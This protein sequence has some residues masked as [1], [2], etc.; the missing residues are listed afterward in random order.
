VKGFLQRLDESGYR[1]FYLA[2]GDANFRKPDWQAGT[3][4]LSG[5]L[6]DFVG[7]FLLQEALPAKRA[8]RLLDREFLQ[9]LVQAGI[10]RQEKNTI[11]SDSFYLMYCRS[12]AF[13][14]QMNATPR[15]YFG[16]DSVALAT[17]QTPVPG[18][19][20]LDLC[21]GPGIQSFIAAA[22]AASVTGVEIRKETVRVAEINRRLNSLESRVR[23]IC[24]SVEDFAADARRY[25]RIL[26]NPPLVPMVP[27]YKFSSVG[28]GGPDGLTLSRRILDLYH[29]RITDSGSIEFIGM[30]LGNEKH[31]VVADE[32]KK[33]ARRYRLGGRIHLLSQHPIQPLTPM[34]EVCVS[35]LASE[36]GLEAERAREILL[37]HFTG[38]G[39]DTYWLFFAALGP[40]AA[41]RGNAVSTIDLTGTFWG[42]WFV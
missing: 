40:A 32:I 7:L 4:T 34:F 25:D 36:N 33:I 42:H 22:S 37:K 10:L 17:L 6:R 2:F 21:S 13:F 5:P 1:Q 26:F 41:A 27:G 39:M 28:N 38:L 18:G 16:E 9:M 14:C 19:T 8:A 35:G 15:A 11:V 20:V 23:F 12:F 31:P 30:G 3:E 29:D 24:R